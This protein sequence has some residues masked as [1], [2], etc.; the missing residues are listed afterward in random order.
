MSNDAKS[1]IT[2]ASATAMR[3]VL[4]AVTPALERAAGGKIAISYTT[5]GGNAKRV[6]AG[7]AIDLVMIAQPDIDALMQQGKLLAGSDMVVAR[8]DVGVGVRKGTPKPDVS[9]VEAFKGALLA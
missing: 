9:T 3:E 2:I 6:A 4:I 5:S 8:S 1:E 7:E